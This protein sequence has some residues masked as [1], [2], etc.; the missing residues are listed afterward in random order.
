MA[1][2]SVCIGIPTFRRPQYLHEL[3]RKVEKLEGDQIVRII[4]ADNDPAL[5]EGFQTCEK[6]RAEGFRY[7]LDC[8]VCPEKGIAA[9]RNAIV[10]AALADDSLTHLA[11]IDDDSWPRPNWIAEL[12]A[13]LEKLS[14]DVVRAAMLPDFEKTPPDWLVKTGYYHSPYKSTGRIPQIHGGGNF[15]ASMAVFTGV[16]DPW[17]S[18]DYA[19]TGGED[20]DFFLRVKELGFT[21]GQTVETAVYER[22]P[23]SRCN[24]AWLKQ[25]AVMNGASWANIRMKRRPK[26]WTPILELS[27]VV[28]GFATGTGMLLVFFWSR[29]RAFRG[30]YQIYRSA[31]KIRGLL[32]RQK[33]HYQTH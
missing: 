19:L 15:L 3:L 14:V 22:M 24:A 5:T 28:T 12:L 10:R 11:M 25:R 30:I 27:K 4:V 20:D 1:K 21:F 18:N 26:G 32:S 13:T 23:A 2:A 6:I 9:N 17:F 7:R 33:Q 16:G 31:G 29:H 8:V